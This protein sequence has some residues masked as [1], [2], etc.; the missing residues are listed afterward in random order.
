MGTWG[1]GLY[2]NDSALDSLGDLLAIGDD[3]QDIVE[4]TTRI[5]LAAWLNPV[6]VECDDGP[7]EEHVKKLSGDLEKL[8]E[9]TRKALEALM[10]DPET[11]LKEGSRKPEIYAVIGGYSNGPRIDA[12]LRF[13]GAIPIVAAFGEEMAKQLDD[14]LTPKKGNDLY[15]VA[16]SL[17][18]LGIL[19]ELALAGMFQ[20]APARVETWRAEFT[21]IDKN[22]KSERG[23]WWKYVRRVQT[24]FDLLAPRP[25]LASAP[26]PAARPAKRPTVKEETAPIGPVERYQHPKLGTGVLVGRSG[27]GDEEKLDLRFEDGSIRKILA[28]F[29]TR[30]ED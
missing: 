29:V 4:L 5:G 16:G 13:P 30:L 10:E 7:L 2:D 3:I 25:P 6:T 28:K 9:D 15:Q 21:A 23:F 14:A 26:K 18:V 19:I 12:L 11:A 17:A 1:E 20:P 24:G 27:A 8:P 22:T